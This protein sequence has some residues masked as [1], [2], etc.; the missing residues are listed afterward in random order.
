MGNTYKKNE[1]LTE[2]MQQEIQDSVEEK[3]SASEDFVRK[4]LSGGR[5]SSLSI[6]N[7]IPFIL[8]LSFLGI[9]YIAN[10]HYAENT[11]RKISSL[12]KEVKVMSW[13]FKTL[14]ADMML[15]STQSEVLKLVDT[16]GLRE[17]VVP[18]RKIVIKKETDKQ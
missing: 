8:F 5:L 18:P 2:K 16:V 13:E 7:N 14:K 10:R 4:V 15:R 9:I 17:L 3:A 1:P 11:V 12:S 6:V